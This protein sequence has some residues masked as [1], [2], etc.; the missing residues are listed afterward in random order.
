[1]ILIQV[2]GVLDTAEADMLIEEGV[3]HIGFPL[4][5]PV[6]AEDTTEAE[7][8]EII[9]H[10][11]DRARCVLITYLDDWKEIVAFA[12]Y[13]QVTMVQLHGDVREETLKELKAN[14]PDLDLIKSLVVSEDNFQVLIETIQSLSSYVDWFITDTFDPTTGASGATGKTH[15]WS[16]GRRLI[17]ISEKPVIIAGG[18]NDANIDKAV[19]HLK[20]AGVDAH[21]GLE[22]E[23]GRKDRA[24]VRGFVKKTLE[25]FSDKF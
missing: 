25:A 15:D 6:N 2:A 21:T 16:V 13:L 4:R 9:A 20:P 14:R 24:K 7:A 22:N 1:M 10:I 19:R 8:R 3:T 12:D 11:G 17:D 5:L 23:S 18:L